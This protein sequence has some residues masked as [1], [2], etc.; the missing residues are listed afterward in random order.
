MLQG[1]I[2]LLFNIHKS[3]TIFEPPKI[4]ID[5]NTINGTIIS[6]HD[7]HRVLKI[8]DLNKLMALSYIKHDL[9]P[10]MIRL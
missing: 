2:L 7:I 4:K 10:Y 5:Y 1:F 9:I 3:L 6:T 8:Y